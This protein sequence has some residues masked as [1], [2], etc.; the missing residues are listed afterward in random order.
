MTGIALALALRGLMATARVVLI[1][2]YLARLPA[3]IRGGV[4][5]WLCCCGVRR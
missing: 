3:D 5:L 4:A 1:G 2:R